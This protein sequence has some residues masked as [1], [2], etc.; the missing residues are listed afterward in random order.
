MLVVVSM[1]IW[2]VRYVQYVFLVRAV[3]IPTLITHADPFDDAYSRKKRPRFK[4]RIKP[5]S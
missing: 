2:D 1:R 3:N 4:L 5:N